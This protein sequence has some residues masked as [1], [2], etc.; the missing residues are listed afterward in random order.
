MG[1]IE[2]RRRATKVDVVIVGAGLAGLYA[3]QVL[4]QNGAS[5]V[6]LEARDRVGGRT[7]SQ[8]IGSGIFDLGGQW[9]GPAQHRM[10]KLVRELGIATFPTH[11]RGKK[12]MDVDGRLSTYEGTLPSLSLP[13][14]LLL[15]RTIA[16]LDKM[17]KQVPLAEPYAARH[18]AAWDGLTLEAWKR[19]AIP[20]AA[21]RGV[22]DVAVR[23]VFG[24]EPSDLSF[25]HF[26]FYLNSGGGLMSLVEIEN[27][28]QQ[29]RFVGGAQQV[30]LRLA[31]RLGERVVLN[32]P[33][34]S[35]EQGNDHVTARTGSE[36]WLGRYAI[37]AVPPALAGR[38]HYQPALPFLRDQL[39]QRFPMGATI[40]CIATYERPFWRERGFSGEALCTRGPVSV[41]FDNT[42]HDGAQPA[43]LGFLVGRAARELG[44]W[45]PSE[46]QEAVLSSFVRFFGPEAARPIEYYEKD[47]S[48]EPWTRGCPAG[49]TTPG[50][51]TVFG[52]ALRAPIGRIHWA[53]TE[54]AVEWN[55]YMEGAIESGERAAQEVLV[56]L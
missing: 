4:S 39:T 23:V 19:R 13:N 31:E 35:I 10:A 43:L 34:L 26:L 9:L 7:L 33:V 55:G 51:L 49:S 3:A 44:N 32:A 29:D 36:W 12:V 56:R 1:N 42:T 37:V 24:A 54:T 8:R 50:T 41:V 47:W 30:A 52:K 6:V 28:A 20:F 40:K 27:G 11:A 48:A 38:I 15:R 2:D 16:T 25:L 46:R 5:V 45:L 22:L 21:V 14:L 17:S 18:S 53:S